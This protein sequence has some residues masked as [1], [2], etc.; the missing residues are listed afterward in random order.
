MILWT[1]NIFNGGLTDFEWWASNFPSIA[2][3]LA[4]FIPGRALTAGITKG[5]SFINKL[6]KLEKQIVSIFDETTGGED[7]VKR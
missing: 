5:F 3:S 4:L 7:V 6:G 2:T 1:W